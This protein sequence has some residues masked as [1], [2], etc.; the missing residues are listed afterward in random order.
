MNEQGVD[1]AGLE[2]GEERDQRTFVALALARGALEPDRGAVVAE[3]LV[4]LVDQELGRELLAV[5]KDQRD[6]PR[7][8]QRRSAASARRSAMAAG[9]SARLPGVGIVPE[10]CARSAA[11]WASAGA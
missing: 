1:R 5:G 10:R 8:A 9:S 2:L 3:G 4:D 11:R 6:R 7:A